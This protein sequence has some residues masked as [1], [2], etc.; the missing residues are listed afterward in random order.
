MAGATGTSAIGG[1]ISGLDT[2]TLI[3]Q[4]IAV[5]RKRVDLVVNNQAEQSTKLTSYQSLNTQLL[6]FQ[7]AAESLK[8]S[9]T[10]DVFKTSSST[11]STNFT[12]DELVGISATSDAS[13]GTHT[14]KFTSTSQLAQARKL[15][16]MSFSSSTDALNLSGEFT[17]NGKGISVSTT[18]SLADIISTI[19][20]ANSGIDA[21]GVTA[22][23]LSVSD[24]DNR[25]VLTS[26]N[27]GEDKFTLLDASS[28]NILEGGTT[29]LG[30]ASSTKSIKNT[31]SDGMKSDEFS[32]S[33]T[34]IKSLLGLTGT[35]TDQI[36]TIGGNNVTINLES[37]SLSDIATAMVTAGITA[38]VVSTT[39]DDGET[40][41][42]LDI[43]ET[44]SFTDTNNT[45]EALGI[46]ERSQGSV[47]EIHT[48]SISNSEISGASGTYIT[49]GTTFNDINT[50]SDANN[51]VNADE[52][53]LS[54]TKHDGTAVT[55]T[56]TI[57]DITTDTIDGLLSQ[58][59]TTFGLGSSSADIDSSGQIIITD[60]TSGDSQLS[61][62]IVSN[63]EGGGTLDFGTVS[64]TTEGYE[65]ESTAGQDAKVTIDG[66]AV[67]RSSNTID[68]VISGVTLDLN[69][70][71]SGSEVDLTISRDTD[72]IK[73]KV[74]EFTT[75]YNSIIEFINQE[76]SYNED[77]KTSGVLSGESTLRTIKSIIQNTLTDSIPQLPTDANALSLIGIVSDKDGKLSVEDS[78]FLS[79]INSDFYAVK[80]MFVAEGTTTDNEI[81]YVSHSSD[82]VAGDY[83]VVINTVA[84][85]ATVT[86]SADLSSGASSTG[87]LT[88]TDTS[89]SRVATV[90]IT[91]GDSLDTIV[92]AINSELA[93]ESTQ[94]L[95]GDVANTASSS[96]ITA[97]TVLS[98]IDGATIADDDTI[99][100]IGTNRSGLSV[101][102]TFTISVTNGD[103][104]QDFLSTIES[105]YD[106]T[107]SAT[108]DT[109]G[110]IIVTDN[111]A[112]DSQISITITTSNDLDF[113]N[114]LASNTSEGGVTGRYAMEITASSVSGTNLA[115]THDSYGS[116]YGFTTV[117]TVSLL[118]SDST[119]AGVDVAG[120][121][122]GEDA[123]GTGQL[124]VGDTPPDTESTTS[125]ED[126]A[127]KVTST[128]TGSKGN[129][130]LTVGVGELM[131]N[132]IDS[133]IDGIDGLLTIRMDGIQDTIDDMQES[134]LA[135]EE[136]L[137][138]ETVRLN[139]QFVALE[140]NLSKLQSV[141]SFMAQ[142]LS[143]LSR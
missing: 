91:N 84:T 122:N 2:A 66:V 78:T 29:G 95:A 40:T 21:T 102:N 119:Y 69:R 27:T 103:T 75:A 135:M 134:I 101:S 31:T 70:V 113:G 114:V 83:A 15:S 51:V 77:T 9:D 43:S 72:T 137:A 115:L 37:D 45:L 62:S 55:G 87:S 125:V 25:M 105:A 34:A 4:L 76:F 23:L 58:I 108:I 94:I 88:I 89:T 81:S 86:G 79:E 139:K 74:S 13:P 90:S 67:T 117:E 14:V 107:V 35:F 98:D 57:S 99:S 80:R 60:D 104:V 65:M 111:T 10:F 32:S 53:T 64:V 116:G 59:E 131:Y 54:G 3:E 24:T 63:N 118:G 39:D 100:F 28:T 33:T 106:N 112:G 136:R 46:L 16:S 17:I 109:S 92:S 7:S 49:T 41:Y 61:I 132:D 71:E 97:S 19:N 11:D 26:D 143:M 140:L 126:L 128:S 123:T 73:N 133:I 6:S 20:T 142:Q 48:G 5:S 120:T 85:Q 18:D 30:L 129:V 52:I 82:T 56:Y 121:I 50:G 22:S 1:L 38:S 8:D 42:Q 138:M 12:A 127:I 44:T 130:E 96:P 141:S 36:V 110:R 124:L 47:A 93:T 68:D